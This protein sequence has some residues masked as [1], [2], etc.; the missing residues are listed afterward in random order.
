MDRLRLAQVLEAVPNV[1]VAEQL[2]QQPVADLLLDRLRE[3][4][5]VR[6]Q[7]AQ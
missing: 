2:G 3:R 6:G 4:V 7:L 1:I 5:R